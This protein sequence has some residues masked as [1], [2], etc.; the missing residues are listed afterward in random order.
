MNERQKHGF[1]YEEYIINKNNLIKEN[2]YTSKWDGYELYKGV[3][4]PVSVKC[5]KINSNIEFGD[6]KRQLEINED[7]ILYVGF[8]ENNKQNIIEEYK[9][10]IKKDSW[11]K[12]FGN[13]KIIKQML[14]ELKT[15]SNS[16]F[17]DNKWLK[18]RTKYKESYG[19]SILSLRFKRD[20]KK[21]KRIQCA[22]TKNNFI[23]K[24]IKD[25]FLILK[26]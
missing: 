26:K 2:N 12:Y 25:N 6:F 16:Y 22:I 14:D 9:I 20:H 11:C 7:F 21:Q 10:L 15:I 18:Y 13:K 5:M 19:E 23:N 8:W 4:T 24:V 17:D 3:K 1:I